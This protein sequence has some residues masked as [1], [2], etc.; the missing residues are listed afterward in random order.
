MG[1]VGLF[2]C[3]MWACFGMAAVA[4][5]NQ[6][7]FVGDIVAKMLPD[8]R[9]LKVMQDFTYVDPQGVRWEV[10]AGTETDGASVPAAFWIAYP[11]FTGKY[12]MAAVVHDRYCQTHER[13]WRATHKAFYDAMLTAGVDGTT[14]K[15]LYGAV[16]AMGPRWGFGAQTRGPEAAKRSSEPQ[17]L[18]FMNELKNWI[19]RDNPTPKQIEEA[20]EAGRIP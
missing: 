6:G 15:L 19:K 18:E 20:T 9:N 3:A 5:E 7:A 12:R 13:V 16:Y 1:R 2:L 11:P 14:A 10:P 8:G 17:Q 4:G